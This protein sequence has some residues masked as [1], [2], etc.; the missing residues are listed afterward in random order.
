MYLE[1]SIMTY[2]EFINDILEKRGRFACENVYHERH[3][4]IPRSCGGTDDENNLI[5]LLG[6]EHYIAHKLLVEENPDNYKLVYALWMMGNAV[7]RKGMGRYAPSAEEY[8]FARSSFSDYHS[9]HHGEAMKKFYE[10]NPDEKEK[11]RDEQIKFYE[12]NEIIK[13]IISERSKKWWSD[14]KN[15]KMMSERVKG[16]NNPFYGRHHTNEF[17]EWIKKH[18]KGEIPPN[19][20]CVYCPELNMYFRSQNEAA[21]YL[22]MRGRSHITDCICGHRNTCGKHPETGEPLHWRSI[23]LDLYNENVC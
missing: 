10:D 20:M 6:R 12:D 8:E 13:N 21:R 3:H 9:K 11:R 2:I 1:V 17:K 4:I 15:K 16:E 7:N 23:S 19:A 22:G 14:S 18:N 5:D